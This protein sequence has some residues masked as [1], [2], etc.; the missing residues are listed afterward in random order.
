MAQYTFIPRKYHLTSTFT[1]TM[2]L[3]PCGELAVTLYD[4]SIILMVLGVGV[5]FGVVLSWQWSRDLTTLRYWLFLGGCATMTAGL[6]LGAF[7]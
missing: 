7:S 5:I 6:V 2:L 3:P 1:L 4:V